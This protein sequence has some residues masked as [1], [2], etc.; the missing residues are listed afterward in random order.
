M[1][2]AH[3]FMPIYVVPPLEEGILNTIWLGQRG[4][5]YLLCFTGGSQRWGPE[6]RGLPERPRAEGLLQ[7]HHPRKILLLYVPLS[8]LAYFL[9]LLFP[10]P[11]LCILCRALLHL[12]LNPPPIVAF[13]DLTTTRSAFPTCLK[14]SMYFLWILRT[15]GPEA[16]FRMILLKCCLLCLQTASHTWVL[17]LPGMEIVVPC[18]PTALDWLSWITLDLYIVLHRYQKLS[19]FMS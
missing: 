12:I 16:P 11:R 18:I 6:P 3:N 13:E 2:F 9:I 10:I 17:G 14:H 4:F 1:H 8:L 15:A 19:C 7:I 5:S